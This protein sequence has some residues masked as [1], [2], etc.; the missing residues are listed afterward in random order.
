[1]NPHTNNVFDLCTDRF[2]NQAFDALKRARPSSLKSKRDRTTTP[3]GVTLLAF[4]PFLNGSSRCT[5]FSVVSQT[6]R[7]LV[8]SECQAVRG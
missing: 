3:L 4:S 8:F 1:M 5:P 2:T 7:P 6:G